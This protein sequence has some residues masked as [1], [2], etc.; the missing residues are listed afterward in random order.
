MTACRLVDA[1]AVHREH[2]VMRI[3]KNDAP[4]VDCS[5]IIMLHDPIKLVGA[6][7]HFEITDPEDKRALVYAATLGGQPLIGVVV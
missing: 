2:K 1:K 5:N 3:L 4:P 7:N 6:G